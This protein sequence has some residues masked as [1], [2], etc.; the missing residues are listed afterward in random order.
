M[1]GGLQLSELKQ[2]HIVRTGPMV[3]STVPP[4]PVFAQLEVWRQRK[5][6]SE[7]PQFHLQGPWVKRGLGGRQ[8]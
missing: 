6:P 2:E 3:Y 4:P 5:C 8:L 7:D 1:L